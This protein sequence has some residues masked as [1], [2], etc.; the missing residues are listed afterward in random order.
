MVR[1]EDARVAQFDDLF[2]A[3][4]SRA[5]QIAFVFAKLDEEAVVDVAL[6]LLSLQKVVIDAIRLARLGRS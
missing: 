4:R 3:A 6:H 2:D 1:I 5:V